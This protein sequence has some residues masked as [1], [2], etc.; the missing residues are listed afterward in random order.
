MMARKKKLSSEANGAF[1]NIKP[2]SDG[3][4][5]VNANDL[6]YITS[7][8]G[9]G[10]FPDQNK[11]SRRKGTYCDHTGF[12][13]FVT[14]KGNCYLIASNAENTSHLIKAGYTE[15]EIEVEL[16]E[17]ASCP[18]SVLTGYGKVEFNEARIKSIARTLGLDEDDYFKAA[19]I[20]FER[21]GLPSED[22]PA[23]QPAE[24]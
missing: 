10:S 23:I 18:G 14:P 12:I 2:L 8:G 16:Y 17:W 22:L 5:C 6:N 3:I 9:H 24:Q 19:E 21:Y 20:L 15:S 4:K 7:L 11:D 13:S 1:P